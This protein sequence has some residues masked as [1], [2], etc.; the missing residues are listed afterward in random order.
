MESIS[1]EHYVTIYYCTMTPFVICLDYLYDD[2]LALGHIFF[3]EKHGRFAGMPY[4][5]PA[6]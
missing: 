5:M 2:G 1:F 4:N 6:N 3:G